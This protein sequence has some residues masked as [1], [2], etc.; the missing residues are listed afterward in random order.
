MSCQSVLQYIYDSKTQKVAILTVTM[1]AAVLFE[2]TTY[3]YLPC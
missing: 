2:V 1:H 3:V